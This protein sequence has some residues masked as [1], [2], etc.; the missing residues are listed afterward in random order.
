MQTPIAASM[1]GAVRGAAFGW[2]GAALMQTS[3]P[4]PMTFT[5]GDAA[6]SC[7]LG[8]S[9]MLTLLAHH[10]SVHFPQVELAC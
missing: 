9:L 4:S 10:F 2:L 8:A 7:K 1:S 6:C 3:L 5:K